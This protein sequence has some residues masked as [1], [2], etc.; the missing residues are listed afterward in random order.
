MSR[1][2]RLLVMTRI[3]EAGRVKTRLI[4]ALGPDGASHLHEALLRHTLR[5]AR[6]WGGPTDVW[7]TGTDTFPTADFPEAA[8]FHPHPQGTGDLGERLI[9][10]V[11]QACATEAPGGELNGVVVIGTDC[12]GLT[13]TTLRQAA[14]GLAK[15]D[16]VL[17]PAEDGGYYLIALRQPQPALFTGIDWGTERVLAQTLEACRGLGLRVQQLAPLADVDEPE[18]LLV[19]RREGIPAPAVLP[20]L[21]PG[22]LSVVI[23][24]KNE[25]RTL[26]V[27]VPPLLQAGC[28]V[29]V[30][31]GGSDDD[32]AQVAR[33]LGCRVVPTRPVRGRQLNAG[34]ALAR[35]EWL[36]FLHAD[37][38]L[39]STFREDI[40]ATLAQGAIAGAFRLQ[41]D[42]AGWGLRG[43]AWGANQ[44]SRWLQ[45]PYGDQGLFLRTESFHRL[46]GFRPWPLL[47]DLEFCQ[48]L[49]QHGSIAL[50]PTAVQ[51]S[52]R[53][54]QQLGVART[55]LINQ[56]VLLR[57]W[58]GES[59]ER[60]AAFYRRQKG[61][62]Q[63]AGQPPAT[64]PAVQ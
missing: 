3:P 8:T 64:P 4:P 38:R 55:T 62:R 37:T 45:W 22:L 60:L 7:F 41:I 49:K 40:P 57:Y 54:W 25:A 27:T 31:D 46:G 23:P 14:D 51:T 48:R 17:G 47:E 53:R 9:R 1:Q 16:V 61:G 18:D 59:P 15:H 11:A 58:W 12:P 44:R 20:P 34:A 21:E 29:L 24:V 19:C 13:E 56:L 30:A 39:P 28:E 52:A 35:G 63:T 10:A 5:Q 26:P 32:T 50:A 33:E 42:S 36:L 43:V 2:T 6:D